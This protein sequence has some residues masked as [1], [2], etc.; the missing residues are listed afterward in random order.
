EMAS[1]F[2]DDLDA[3]RRTR[4]IADRCHVDFDFNQMHL[5]EYQVPEGYNLDSYLHKLCRERLSGRYPQGV[6]QEAEERLAHELQIIQQTGFSG[7]FLIVE[8]FVS[9]ARAQGIPVGPGR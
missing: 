2:P 4:E 5:P 6:S 7:Y 9:W 3:L 1:L 8:D